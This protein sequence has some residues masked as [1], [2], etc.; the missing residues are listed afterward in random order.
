MTAS[1]RNKLVAWLGLAAMWLAVCAPVVSQ[2]M[3]R[4]GASDPIARFAVLCSASGTA[5]LAP[6]ERA[7]D[8]GA[9]PAHGAADHWKACGYCGLLAHDLPL[10][11]VP[12][13]WAPPRLL[14][15]RS[16]APRDV[17]VHA[18]QHHSLSLARGPPAF[19]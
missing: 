13:V 19:S 15:Y 11:H 2:V 1:L 3:A 18:S 4:H 6:S 7:Q 17:A 12:F 9:G 10:A 14:A 5:Q 8:A 16:M